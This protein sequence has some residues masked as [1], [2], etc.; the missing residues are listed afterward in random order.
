MTQKTVRQWEG[1]IGLAQAGDVDAA[2]RLAEQVAPEMLA[3][4]NRLLADILQLLEEK[5]RIQKE[6]AIESAPRRRSYSLD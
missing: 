5:E 4:C 3:E 2:K 1:T 6:L